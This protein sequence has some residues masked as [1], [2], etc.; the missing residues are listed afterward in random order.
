MTKTKYDLTDE[1]RANLKPWA[2]KWTKI[3]MSTAAMDD[4][5]KSSVRDAI[6]AMYVA[7]GMPPP[8]HIVF[9]SSPLIGNVASGF[10]AAI[11]H[12]AATRA[13]TWAA[14]SDATRAATSDATWAETR[15]ETRAATSAETRGWAHRLALTIAPQAAHFL[16]S[17]AN[18][19][20]NMA[21]GGNHWAQDVS[22][23]SFFDHVAGLA[24]P[25]Y[26]QWRHYELAAIHGSWRWVHQ[27]FCIVSDRPSILLVDDRNRP[28]CADGPSHQWRDGW[29]LYFWHGV[30]VP[31]TVIMSPQSITTT[32]IDDEPNQE[33][34][35]VMI[36]RYGYDKYA[37]ASAV[38]HEDRFGKLRKRRNKA[39]DD[40]AVVEVLNSTPEPDGSTK[41]YFLAVPPECKTALEA[42]AWTFDMRPS[43]YA[44]LQIQT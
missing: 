34:R 27:D 41:T 32:M 10:S 42:V 28:H 26:Q 43:E 22:W 17:C 12:L 8:R 18:N 44:D 5:D 33:V 9:V 7:G 29:S 25:I 14:T 24:L 3:I 30:K 38:V 40:I 1:H 4:A 39:G 2:E 31:E 21:N 16:V 37:G 35:R 36:E 20:M 23:L 6:N 11:W 15:A 13:A 19:A